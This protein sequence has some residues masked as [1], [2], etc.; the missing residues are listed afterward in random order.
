MIKKLIKCHYN[1]IFNRTSLSLFSILIFIVLLTNIYLMMGLDSHS[2][3]EEMYYFYFDS[4]F[5]IISFLGVIFAIILFS[6]PFLNKQDQYIYFLLS[7]NIT[8]VKYFITKYFTILLIL[9]LFIVLE[10]F[11]FYFPLVAFSKIK[12]AESN[13]LISFLNLFIE[14]I[15]YGNISL[16]LIILFDNFYLS[17]IPIALF[18]FTINLFTEKINLF[19]KL[20]IVSMKADG[21]VLWQS[22]GQ[23]LFIVF[24]LFFVSVILY[25]KKDF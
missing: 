5:S 17:L 8:K 21:W 7:N 4:S 24:I 25:N 22:I 12:F 6:F 1:Y 20:F 18:L 13:S 2:D 23:A 11:S 3:I 19:C 10:M 14:M 15:Y 9:L 16:I